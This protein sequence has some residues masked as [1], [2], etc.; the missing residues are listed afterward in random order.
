MSV[1]GRYDSGNQAEIIN[2]SIT[3]LE[4]LHKQADNELSKNGR[5]SSALGVTFGI[6]IAIL[7]L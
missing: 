4:E 2:K 5:I 3:R 7:L 6:V 1:F